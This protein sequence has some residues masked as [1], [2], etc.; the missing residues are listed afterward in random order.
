MNF[1][2]PDRMALMSSKSK[3]HIQRVAELASESGCVVC[4][5]PFAHIHHMLEDRTPGRRSSDW[6]VMG[7]CWEC[8]EGRHGIHGDRDRWKLRNMSESKALAKTLE[9]VYGR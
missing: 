5:E 2:V 8:H 1:P 6:L 7:L 9:A 4:G 3:R